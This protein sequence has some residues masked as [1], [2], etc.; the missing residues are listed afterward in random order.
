MQPRV[1]NN[2]YVACPFQIQMCDL[3]G[4]IS[5]GTAFFYECKGETFIITNWHN[6][7]G[8]HPLTGEPLHSTRNPSFIRAKWPV[9]DHDAYQAD[10]A[11]RFH[12]EAQ[13][14]EM[15]DEAGPLWFE[16]PQLGSLCDVVAIPVQKPTEWPN[17]IHRAANKIDKTLIPI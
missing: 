8:K 15:E 4:G 14:V 9:V 17:S 11:K 7:T 3:Q 13:N 12:F 1:L 6:V 10:G 2:Y 5:L 16:H